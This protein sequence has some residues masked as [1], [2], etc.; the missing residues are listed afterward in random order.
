MTVGGLMMVEPAPFRS[1]VLI[2]DRNTALLVLHTAL[3]RNIEWAVLPR[4]GSPPRHSVRS[5]HTS[6]QME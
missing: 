2:P 1:I 6:W 5:V 3:H 4:T